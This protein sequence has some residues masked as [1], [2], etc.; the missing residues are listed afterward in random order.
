[1]PTLESH[2]WHLCAA[3]VAESSVSVSVCCHHWQSV[4]MAEVLVNGFEDGSGDHQML[5][6]VNGMYDDDV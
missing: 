5:L 3:A 4:S 1:M 6:S 2:V